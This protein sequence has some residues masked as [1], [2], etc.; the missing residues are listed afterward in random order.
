ILTRKSRCLLSSSLR[1]AAMRRREFITL[2][3]GAAAWPTGVRAQQAM[4]KQV[5]E[6]L[7]GKLLKGLHRLARE[8]VERVPSLL[9]EAHEL[10]PNVC[11]LL[12]HEN[13]PVANTRMAT[14]RR[15]GVRN[16]KLKRL[17]VDG[18]RHRRAVSEAFD[19]RRWDGGTGNLSLERQGGLKREA[20]PPNRGAETRGTLAFLAI[21]RP[22]GR[23]RQPIHAELAC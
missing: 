5:P 2:L 6:R 19:P 15:K 1:R 17:I 14:A 9:I 3:G 7:I 10:A 13:S 18:I 16:E 12:G 22:R 23:P 21:R 4:P 8:Q 11:R 20:S